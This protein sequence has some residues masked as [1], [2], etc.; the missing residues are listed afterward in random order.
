M[1]MSLAKKK[2]RPFLNESIVALSIIQMFLASTIPALKVFQI[3]VELI[4]IALLLLG[5]S[6]AKLD[7][8]Q[9]FILSTLLMV[10]TFSIVTSDVISFMST[11]KNNILGV[12]ALVYFSN[13]SFNSKLIFPVFIITTL[14]LVVSFINPETMLPLIAITFNDEFNFS[15]FGGIFLNT[16]FNAY[17]M[18]IA[19]IY[20]SQWKYRYGLGG[21]LA[22]YITGSHTM[23]L[24]YTG[25][26][27]TSLP[28]TKF[29]TRHRK[30]IIIIISLSLLTIL[31]LIVKNY[32][33]ILDAIIINSAMQHDKYNSIITILVQLSEPAYWK[34]LLNPFP[35]LS[36]HMD[37][38]AYTR[39]LPKIGDGTHD[40]SNEIGVFGLV[41][42]CGIF[43]AVT[44]LLMLLK[45]AKYYSVFIL[46]SLVHYNF[47]LSPIGVYMM[48]EYSRRIQLLRNKRAQNLAW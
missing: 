1:V 10:T 13:V 47:I 26:I 48:V 7:K 3:P 27:A 46:L 2:L 34:Q 18:A 8:W 15:R 14:L 28:V 30:K 19:L 43:L 11:G 36:Q 44:Y 20:Y 45:N 33:L 25:Q 16:H 4:L 12:L 38:S 31:L 23:G 32:F 24:A 17:F 21:L 22:I 42:Q 29:T 37:E 6:I 35:N 40:G 5:C 41:N 39:V 9:A